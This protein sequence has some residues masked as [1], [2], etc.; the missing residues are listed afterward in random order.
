MTQSPSTPA[1]GSATD[2]RAPR[3]QTLF[4]RIG[5]AWGLAGVTVALLVAVELGA[6]AVFPLRG[7]IELERLKQ[8][9]AL[10]GADWLPQLH[11]EQTAAQQSRWEPFV[12][13]RIRPSAGKLLNV[14]ENGLRRT[15]APAASNDVNAANNV[16]VFCFGGSAMWG[17]LARDEH[18]IPSELAAA[19]PADTLPRPQITNFAQIGYVT[20]QETFA[21]HRQ[22]QRQDRADLVILFDGYNDL[23][24]TIQNLRAGDAQ[25]EPERAAEFHVTAAQSLLLAA[26]RS[27]TGRLAKNLGQMLSRGQTP[28]HGDARQLTDE[29]IERLA[30]GVVEHY[31]ANLQTVRGMA[32]EHDFQVL[33]YWQPMVFTKAARSQEEERLVTLKARLADLAAAVRRRLA[34]D[35]VCRDFPVRDLAELFAETPEEVFLDEVHMTEAGNAACARRILADVE[36]LLKDRQTTKQVPANSR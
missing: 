26:R 33:A 14:D 15:V 32:R 3:L 20:T 10:A 25:H 17:W 9:S 16:R 7:D 21:L 2:G 34:E 11:Q 18:T 30:Q 35:T 29:D 36:Q 19:W 1:T 13:W 31:A 27:G 6:Q 8:R 23:L 5:V 28:G 22:L 4:S 24:S 12:Y